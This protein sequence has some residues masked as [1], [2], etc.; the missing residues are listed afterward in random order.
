[1]FVYKKYLFIVFGII[2]VFVGP[3]GTDLKAVS[4]L[5]KFLVS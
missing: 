3:M 5:M 2:F 1:M 4:K